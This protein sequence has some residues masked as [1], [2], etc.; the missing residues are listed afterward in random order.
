MLFFLL[1]LCPALIMLWGWDAWKAA[2]PVLLC[3]IML[4]LQCGFFFQL[5]PTTGSGIVLNGIWG[6]IGFFGAG[7]ILP[8]I[9]LPKSLTKVCGY[10]PA[11]ICME[12]FEQIIAGK[13]GAGMQMIKTGILWCLLFGAG[14]QLIFYGK[15]WSKKRK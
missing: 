3:T 10:L 7:G 1:Y 5:A 9:F 8:V 2:A 15:Q 6:M 11:G 4:A 12:L 13:R 14:G